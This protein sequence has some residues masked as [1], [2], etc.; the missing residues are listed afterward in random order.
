VVA[1]ASDS[2]QTVDGGLAARISLA[3]AAERL[4]L[5]DEERRERDEI[6]AELE[7]LR[8]QRQQ[9]SEADYQAA[10]LPHLIRLARI[11]QAAEARVK[12]A[13]ADAASQ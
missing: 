10:L 8:S 7:R 3:P 11:Y 12:D 13:N 4:P 2:S 5:T 9:L 6:E 1:Q